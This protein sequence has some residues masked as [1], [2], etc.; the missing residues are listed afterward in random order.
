M[1]PVAVYGMR[2]V[3]SLDVAPDLPGAPRYHGRVRAN[4]RTRRS[5]RDRCSIRPPRLYMLTRTLAALAGIALAA[6]ST[7]PS[8]VL[9]SDAFTATG[10]FLRDSPTA[11]VL[12]FVDVNVVA[13]DAPTAVAHQ[14]VVVRDGAIAAMGP[15]AAV[16]IPDGAFIL[17][18]EGRLYLLPGLADMHIHLFDRDE[19]L[20]YLANGVTTVRN[21]HGIPRHLA[22]RDSLQ[23]GELIGPRLFTA[24]PILDGDPPTRSTNVVVRTVDEARTEVNRQ[25]DA[26]YDFIKVYDNLAPAVYAAVTAEA[27]RRGR[28]VVGHLPT[29]VGLAG[30][31]A[32]GAQ[33]GVE[34]A[35][36]LLPLFNDGRVTGA[37]T[38]GVFDTVRRVAR[39]F[40]EAGVCLDPTVGVY[41]SALRQSRSWSVES[42]RPEM[43]FV[44]PATRR[45]WGWEEVGRSRSGVAAELARYE[46]TRGFMVN[47][48]VPAFSQAGVRLLAG[49]DAPIPSLIPGFALLDELDLFAAA[50]LTPYQALQAT[51]TN[52]TECLD[53]GQRLGSLAVGR[54]ADLLLVDGNPLTGLAVLRK[55]LGVVIGGR[56]LSQAGLSARLDSL[57]DVYRGR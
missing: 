26:G 53:A 30:V 24:G 51:T 14:T 47:Q 23:R 4:R 31:L 18:G 22:W 1:A 10:T 8:G 54:V 29:P 34:H 11:A 16:P 7:P 19:M 9:P 48:I 21:M 20:L 32:A 57:A 35:E 36:E 12:A 27:R 41:E 56:W 44:N 50:G 43:R 42:A 28:R 45:T 17:R 52:A 33:H 13:M 15:I 38:G 5:P 55:R 6:C 46:R 49:S 3:R 37:S 25:I 39:R 40:A 2:V